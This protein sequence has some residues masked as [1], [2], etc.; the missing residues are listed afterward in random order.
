M[1]GLQIVVRGPCQGMVDSQGFS[2]RI[3]CSHSGFLSSGAGPQRCAGYAG[4][5]HALVGTMFLKSL[6]GA[7][8]QNHG[9]KRGAS[10]DHLGHQGSTASAM[11]SVS[12][13]GTWTSVTPRATTQSLGP[14]ALPCKQGRRTFCS[15]GPRV[16]QEIKHFPRSHSSWSL[17]WYVDACCSPKMWFLQA[18]Q[19]ARLGVMW[20]T[21]NIT[22]VRW[23]S[24]WPIQRSLL[25][26]NVLRAYRKH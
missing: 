15:R 19:Q 16:V 17:S 7:S 4:H 11:V 26:M 8:Q 23:D 5:P 13:I 14:L 21:V 6:C 25:K 22:A 3:A 10:R 12:W 1:H 9:E 20:A 2:C 18:Q 24:L